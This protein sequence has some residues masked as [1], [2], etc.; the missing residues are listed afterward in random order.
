VAIVEI[1]SQ[2]L[3]VHHCRE[4]RIHPGK[5]LAHELKVKNRGTVLGCESRIV[6]KQNA[7][8]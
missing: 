3:I 8:L 6:N 4:K 2:Y 1:P 5:G 7:E